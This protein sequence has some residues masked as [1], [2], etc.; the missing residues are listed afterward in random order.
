MNEV[1]MGGKQVV[2]AVKGACHGHV[3]RDKVVKAAQ[4]AGNLAFGNLGRLRLETLD[5]PDVLLALV[6]RE[7]TPVV[8]RLSVFQASP[9]TC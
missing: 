5:G 2:W 8:G 3:R 6:Y 7:V 9:S 4:G 1:T